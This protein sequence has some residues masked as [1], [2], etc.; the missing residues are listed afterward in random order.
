MEEHPSPSKALP[1]S[2][3]PS[4]SDPVTL[5]SPQIVPMQTDLSQLSVLQLQFCSIEH[6]AS[7]PSSEMVLPAPPPDK[8][9]SVGTKGIINA[10]RRGL[11]AARM[12]ACVI[13]QSYF[14]PKY[15][16]M[17]GKIKVLKAG[18]RKCKNMPIPS[19]HSSDPARNPSPHVVVHTCAEP[20]AHE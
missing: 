13:T 12:T 20:P 16:Y 19:S 11:R 10:V 8:T 9:R 5:P 17:Q 14:G 1:S 4:F 7:Q 18:V 2:H 3:P 6:E 15:S